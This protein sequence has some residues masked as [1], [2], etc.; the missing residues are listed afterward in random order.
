VGIGRSG[1][2]IEGGA[3]ELRPQFRRERTSHRQRS[4]SDR[5]RRGSLTPPRPRTALGAGL[6][7]PPRRRTEGLP[8]SPASLAGRKFARA[9]PTR[10]DGDLRSTFRA[11]S[12]DPRPALAN[13]RDSREP[14]LHGRTETT[15]GQ[16][17][18]RGRETRAQRCGGFRSRIL[19]VPIPVHRQR[20]Q[21]KPSERNERGDAQ[22]E[23]W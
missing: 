18:R 20:R 13:F 23:N 5:A 14:N 17:F 15:F 7:T 10:K 2:R 1:S 9:K 3:G 6:M 11:G 4:A 8:H 22:C 12:G 19:S 21:R 16:P